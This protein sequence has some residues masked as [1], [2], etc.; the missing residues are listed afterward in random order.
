MHNGES[1]FFR[2]H[3]TNQGTLS[4][5]D[6]CLLIGGV[7]SVLVASMEQDCMSLS[8]PRTYIAPWPE[9]LSL[10]DPSSCVNDLNAA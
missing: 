2:V 9:F 4:T 5:R 10:E 6:I 3:A 8:L 1:T 7:P